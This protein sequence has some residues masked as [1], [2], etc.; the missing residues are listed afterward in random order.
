MTTTATAVLNVARSQLGGYYPGKSPYGVWYGDK[1]GSA[2]YDAAAF[3]AMGLSWC[4]AQVDGLDIFPLHAYTPTGVNA[5]KGRGQ[6]H[7]GLSGVRTGD[8]V[9]F[10]FPGGL[11]RVSHVGIVESVNGDGSVNTIE[12][13]TSGNASQTNGRAVVRKRRKVGIVGY[14]RPAYGTTSGGSSGGG[15]GATNYNPWGW[16]KSWVTGI[17]KK[18]IKLGYDLGPAGADGV[19]GKLSNVAVVHFQGAHGLTPDGSPGSATSA[20]L[21]RA[22]AAAAKPA[23][24]KKAAFVG[25]IQRAVHIADD[26]AWGGDTDKATHSVRMASTLHGGKFPYG[27][28]YT[29]DRVGTKRDNSWGRNSGLAHDATTKKIQ[30]ALKDAGYYKGDIDGKWGTGTDGAFV[31]AWRDYAL[32]K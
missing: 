1:V 21:D 30:Q 28:G 27:V 14:G 31:A 18:L 3:C 32:T 2:V 17:Q 10:D 11:N 4:F 12:F 20:A 8:I 26:W 24:P 25:A 5:F 19:L 16:S 13:N 15:A 22:I 23:G 29:Q 9:F 6:W 7:S